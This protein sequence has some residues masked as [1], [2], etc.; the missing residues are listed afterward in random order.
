MNKVSKIILLGLSFFLSIPIISY[1]I[2]E[3]DNLESKIHTK[4]LDTKNEK[5]QTKGKNLLTSESVKVKLFGKK[6][7]GSQNKGIYQIVKQGRLYFGKVLMKL[8]EAEIYQELEPFAKEINAQEYLPKIVRYRGTLT[9][10]HNNVNE[11]VL[12]L[13]PAPGVQLDDF[14]RRDLFKMNREEAIKNLKEIGRKLGNFHSYQIKKIYDDYGAASLQGWV[15]GD[16]VSHLG[17]L[18]YDVDTQN[19]IFIDYEGMKNCEG[20]EYESNNLFKWSGKI[21]ENDSQFLGALLEA[22]LEAFPEGPLRTIT[23]KSAWSGIN[24][25]AGNESSNLGSY[26]KAVEEWKKLADVNPRRKEPV[27]K[28]LRKKLTP[29][30]EKLDH[31]IDWSKTL[32]N[33]IQDRSCLGYVYEIVT[34]NMAYWIRKP[35]DKNDV[36]KHKKA[37]NLS[38]DFNKDADFPQ[39]F[40]LVNVDEVEQGTYLTF[41]GTWGETI[42]KFLKDSIDKMDTKTLAEHFTT[43][44]RTIGSF[45]AKNSKIV[46][47]EYG[48]EVHGWTHGLLWHPHNIIYN[49]EKHTLGFI[50]YGDL[51]YDK[52][53]IK[54]SIDASR[55]FHGVANAL[56]EFVGSYVKNTS[57][58]V[59]CALP[60]PE[61][62]IEVGKKVEVIVHS[63][64]ESYLNAFP[65]KARTILKPS[66][67]CSLF[68]YLENFSRANGILD[69]AT[70][71][72]LK[73]SYLDKKDLDAKLGYKEK[74][75]EEVKVISEY[76]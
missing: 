39:F 10:L 42:N 14:M 16:L 68:L 74:S 72:S 49:P 43:I 4:F 60:L 5:R 36:E 35:M 38:K 21:L 20:S 25:Y 44:G 34:E 59:P 67:F 13:D 18:F 3:K 63:L 32:W 56:G 53:G 76:S 17:N 41:Q 29:I 54:V 24:A 7:E 48:A 37:E 61:E 73:N 33:K 40:P 19:V 26:Q 57:V 6:E 28:A 45:N 70:Y 65:E 75:E 30:L 52:P 64:V 31:K 62:K 46:M 9:I 50:E 15:H 27:E 66:I 23:A 11:H 1:G 55:F 51:G 47:G 2:D 71:D 22:Y 69:I 58:A 8:H 12:L